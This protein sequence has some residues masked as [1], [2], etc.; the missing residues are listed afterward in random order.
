MKTIVIGFS[1]RSHT[2]SSD[3]GLTQASVDQPSSRSV[4]GSPYFNAFI[5]CFEVGPSS[6]GA[7]SGGPSPLVA[8]SDGLK[9]PLV[10]GSDG[11]VAGSDGLSP[12]V[13]GSDGPVAGSD[14]LVAGLDGPSP[15]A[16]GSDG[17]S[18]LDAGSD[19][20]SPSDAAL[21]GFRNFKH[22]W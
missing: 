14:G 20:F 12:L 19:G 22:W 1:G 4:Y 17:F 11:P 18:P 5:S 3:P 16:A 6:L 13:P 15:L 21:N 7:G 10:A 2:Y 8:G 9:S